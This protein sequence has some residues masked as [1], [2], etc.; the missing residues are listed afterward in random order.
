MAVGGFAGFA[1]GG[2]D[3]E[4]EKAEDSGKDG[5]GDASEEM[6]TPGVTVLELIKAVKSPGSVEN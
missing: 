3:A 6:G 4:S 2:K 5:E 1:G